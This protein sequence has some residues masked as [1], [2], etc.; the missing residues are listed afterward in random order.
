MKFCGDSATEV[1]TE[2]QQLIAKHIKTREVIQGRQIILLMLESFRAYVLLD[3]VFGVE[4]LYKLSYPVDKKMGE[5]KQKWL[6]IIAGIK[7]RMRDTLEGCTN[8]RT[9]QNT[10]EPAEHDQSP[11]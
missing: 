5:F 8:T 2:V 9:V 1:S 7:P 6:D 10:Q 3:L 11:E 4:H